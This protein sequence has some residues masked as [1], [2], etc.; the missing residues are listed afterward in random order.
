MAARREELPGR[1]RTQRRDDS[2]EYDEY[3][4]AG[5][6][7]SMTSTLSDGSTYNMSYT[8]DEGGRIAT[9]SNDDGRAYEFSYDDEGGLIWTRRVTRRAMGRVAEYAT[10]R[11]P[12]VATPTFPR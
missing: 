11:V 2:F 7:T 5:R 9:A 10:R 12:G 6:T 1:R 8:Y 3:D 4:N